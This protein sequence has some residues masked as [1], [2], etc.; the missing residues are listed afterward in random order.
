MSERMRKS[1]RRF[2]GTTFAGGA[3]AAVPAAA[4][5]SASGFLT[6]GEM[7]FVRVWVDHMIPADALSPRGT[8]LGIHEFIERALASAWGHGER[9]YL[10]APFKLGS[11]SQGSQLP[12]T[13]A[14]YVRAGI[15]A[16]QKHCAATWG[17]PFEAISEAQRDELLRGLDQF[18]IRFGETLSAK[19]FF[20]LLYG[21]VVQGLFADPSY[22]GNR[23]KAGWKMIGFPGVGGRYRDLIG[24]YRDKPYRATPKGIGDA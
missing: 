14:Q 17:K 13:R 9:M 11:L 6:S 22:G 1:R 20:E 19:G 16:T 5:T 24:K 15:D 8:D 10:S 21:L 4:Q 23:G 7:N 12:Y 2:L 3:L 18:Q